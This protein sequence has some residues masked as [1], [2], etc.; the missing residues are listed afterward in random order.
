MLETSDDQYTF[1]LRVLDGIPRS[2]FVKNNAKYTIGRSS[3]C[4]IQ[5]LDSKASAIN[6][7][8]ECSENKLYVFDLNSTNGTFVN[9]S[10]ETYRELKADDVIRIG[11]TS[12]GVLDYKAITSIKT[13][14]ADV[15]PVIESVKP[16]KVLPKSVDNENRPQSSS[17]EENREVI[18]PTKSVESRKDPDVIVYPLSQ[19]RSFSNSSYIFEE[20]EIYPIFDYDV[21]RP[22][23]EVITVFKDRVYSVDYFRESSK[24]IFFSG[25]PDQKNSVFIPIFNKKEKYQFANYNKGSLELMNVLNYTSKVLHKGSIKELNN[26]NFINDNEIVYYHFGN[27]KVFVKSLRGDTKVKSP[28]LLGR[29]KFLLRSSLLIL[30]FVMIPALLLSLINVDKEKDDLKAPERIAKI[31]YK[32]KVKKT[33]IQEK[34]K[35]VEKKKEV[36]K[37]L[38]KTESPKKSPPKV[39]KKKEKTPQKKVST[40]KSDN[41]AS[42]KP[43]P[44]VTKTARPAPTVTNKTQAKKSISTNRA[45]KKTVA[46]AKLKTPGKVNVYKSKAM[47]PNV[48]S[49]RIKSAS[50]GGFNSGV[51]IPKSDFNSKVDT[52]VSVSGAGNLKSNISS[53]SLNTANVNTSSSDIVDAKKVFSAGVPAKTV[54][55]GSMNPDIIRQLLIQ[56]KP[57]FLYCYQQELSTGRNVNEAIVTEFLIGP[58]GRVSRASVQAS[59]LSPKARQ[60]IANVIKGIQFPEPRGGGQVEVR[61]PFNLSSLSN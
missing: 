47:L 1:E 4:D 53:G 40:R 22:V 36:E 13:N 32:P 23:L 45:A 24:K 31:L 50:S 14:T 3:N 10:K 38:T 41:N 46:K 51:S 57:Q 5:I 11:T 16:P 35:P 12:L 55:L 27:L 20:D 49:L 25:A 6:S 39:E 21:S 42:A 43:K 61:Q 17:L 8:I 9:D 37:K 33:Q 19:D 54:I 26:S 52:T 29:D 7:V 15:P 56:H 48:S 18:R 58:S 44:K 30:I 28:P 34:R 59:Q 2:L 60:C